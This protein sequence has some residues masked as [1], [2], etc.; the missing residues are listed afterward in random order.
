MIHLNQIHSLSDIMKDT[1]YIR[2]TFILEDVPETLEKGIVSEKQYKFVL[3][4]I[5][6]KNYKK[7]DE[8]LPQIG[9]NKKL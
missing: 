6:N 3:A 4:L 2:N 9:I 7:L 8:V 5:F 1:E